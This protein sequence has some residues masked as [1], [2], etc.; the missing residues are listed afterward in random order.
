M[1][2]IWR[3]LLRLAANALIRRAQ[4]LAKANQEA[5]AEAQRAKVLINEQEK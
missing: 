4:K 3:A 1:G 5:R 2:R